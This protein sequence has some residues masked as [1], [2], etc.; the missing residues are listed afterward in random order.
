MIILELKIQI[1]LY[2]GDLVDTLLFTPELLENRFFIGEFQHP[3]L[4]IETIIKSIRSRIILENSE[5]KQMNQ[6]DLPENL[7]EIPMNIDSELVDKFIL[8]YADNYEENGK[9]GWNNHWKSETRLNKLKESGRVFFNL[10][11]D[12]NDRQVITQ[13]TNMEAIEIKNILHKDLEVKDYFIES[14]GIEL[15]FQM[16]VF[17]NHTLFDNKIIPLKGAFDI[18][19]IDHN[20][21]TLRI[22]DFKTSYDAHDFIKSI[23]K[24]GYTTQLSFYDY[25]LRLWLSSNC[26]EESFCNY[27]ILNPINVVIDK[28][29][30][31]PYIY[32]Y[33]WDDLALE[34]EGNENFLFDLYQTKDHKMKIKKGWINILED[35]AW[36]YYN[37]LWLKPKE[38]YENKK[39]RVNLY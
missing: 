39:I 28:Y 22:I 23:K 31:V 8:F 9:K 15:K 17:A 36:H 29:N 6:N 30:K 18:L 2:F 34:R 3:S 38:L 11:Q 10:L 1:L 16:E 25:L 37:D 21:K 7:E 12:A 32:E 27:E 35:I 4:A 19:Q 24:F 26:L 20:N 5:I 14:E 13:I 33:D